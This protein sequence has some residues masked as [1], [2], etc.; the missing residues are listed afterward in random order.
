MADHTL[1]N[2][3]TIEPG[4]HLGVSFEIEVEAGKWLSVG[5]HNPVVLYLDDQCPE[6]KVWTVEV[7]LSV[8]EQDA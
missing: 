8:I 5:T 2:R 1:G 4:D 3:Y 7:S 6:G